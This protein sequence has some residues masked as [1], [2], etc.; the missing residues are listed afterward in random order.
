VA[1]ELD[2]AKGAGVLGGGVALGS[3]FYVAGAIRTGD[4]ELDQVGARGRLALYSLLHFGPKAVQDVR[5]PRA[6][7][8]ILNNE[9]PQ[10]A[11]RGVLG[12]KDASGG[13]SVGPMQVYRATA[14]DLKLW[15]PPEGTTNAQQRILYAAEAENVGRCFSWGVAVFKEKLRIAGGNISEAIRRYNGS[16]PRAEAYRDRAL[17]FA[18]ARGWRLD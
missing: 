9:W 14:L 16:G 7:M 3:L 4:R 11:L 8:A 17:D 1:T 15:T 18:R 10:K 2:V 13:P 12:D 6:L 5:I